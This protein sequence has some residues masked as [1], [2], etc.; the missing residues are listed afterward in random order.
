MSRLARTPKNFPKMKHRAAARQ[1]K[2]QMEA[3]FTF[4]E[5]MPKITETIQEWFRVITERISATLKAIQQTKDATQ[6]DFVLAPAPVV[7]ELSPEIRAR[8]ERPELQFVPAQLSAEQ[9]AV[10]L[11]RSHELAVQ[12]G[13][14]RRYP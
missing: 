8:L 12:R 4:V 11:A 5:Q 1:A 6:A 13:H 2:K 9:T 7:H 3:L 14:I 10:I